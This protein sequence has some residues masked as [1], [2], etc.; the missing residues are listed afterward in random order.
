MK[1]KLL[2][3]LLVLPLVLSGCGAAST[4][5][6]SGTSEE[7]D[8]AETETDADSGEADESTADDDS[9]AEASG[10][11]A[12]EEDME[13]QGGE[14]CGLLV[15]VDSYYDNVY[16]DD[17]LLVL[18]A[19]CQA[20]LVC[21]EGYSELKDALHEFAL[22]EKADMEEFMGNVNDSLAEYAPDESETLPWYYEADVSVKRA[23]REILS[24]ITTDY[25]YLGGAHPNTGIK[26][27]A[28]D[29]KTGEAL[30]LK[31]IVTDYDAFCE[32]VYTALDGHENR[33]GFFDEY[34]ET[35]EEIL[36][37]DGEFALGWYLTSDALKILFN[38]Y[39]LG[40]YALGQVEVTL[41]YADY[42]E[43]LKADYRTELYGSCTKLDTYREYD[44]D[45]GGDT[46]QKLRVDA[47][48]I[49]DEEYNYS[50]GT[51][52]SVY[53][54]EDLENTEP[55]VITAD[56]ALNACYLME[57]PD[58]R[59]F[60]YVDTSEANDYHNLQVFDINTPSDGARELGTA[61]AG[62]LYAYTPT[63]PMHFAVE[64]RIYLFGTYSGY[65][66]CSVGEYGMPE[67]E[68][69]IYLIESAVER[70]TFDQFEDLQVPGLTLKHDYD[71]FNYTDMDEAKDGPNRTLK[72]GD[73][74]YPYCTDNSTYMTFRLE[75]GSFCDIFVDQEIDGETMGEH[76]YYGLYI[77]GEPEIDLFD[78]I[79]YA[80]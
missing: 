24:F 36:N 70:D 57:T 42:P 3:F 31:D 71:V 66:E 26:G 44:L 1:N 48:T 40:P 76:D 9:A 23:D 69:G 77:N 67:S 8:A 61:E 55:A 80:G 52:I 7:A 35:A 4:A 37:S 68:D 73:I 79:I 62:A 51:T 54:G 10:D 56:D 12:E 13:G 25:S 29:V 45:R 75:D 50:N 19:H 28:Y 16:L 20:P 60:L 41:A 53:Y 14:D 47:E 58:G 21:D 65:T 11:E 34:R 15:T 17:E 6:Q 32:A 74:L 64:E 33:E 78:G 49:W 38:E 30:Q 18:Q 27:Y 63:D 72:A 46:L 39:D 2:C 22:S 5:D 59:M 43:L